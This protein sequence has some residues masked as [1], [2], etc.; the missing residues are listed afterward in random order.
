MRA[1]VRA[2][3]LTACAVGGTHTTND[4]LSVSGWWVVG[5]CVTPRLP[6]RRGATTLAGDAD[7]EACG[8]GVFTQCSSTEYFGGEESCR[9]IMREML[10]QSI[11]LAVRLRHRHGCLSRNERVPRI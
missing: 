3:E 8:E 4:V 2:R 10:H 7:T 11:N 9:V 6:T 1:C 5:A